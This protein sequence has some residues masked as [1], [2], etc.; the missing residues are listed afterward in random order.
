MSLIFDSFLSLLEQDLHHGQQKAKALASHHPID[1]DRAFGHES[2]WFVWYDARNQAILELRSSITKKYVG[3][4]SKLER[5]SDESRREAALQNWQKCQVLCNLRN[6]TF[7]DRMTADRRVDPLLGFDIATR[8][9]LVATRAMLTR[10][11]QRSEIA[12]ASG[13]IW[14]S[15]M[16][17]P[18]VCIDSKETSLYDK[19]FDS[20]CMAHNPQILEYWD[21]FIAERPLIADAWNAAVHAYGAPMTNT[22]A[23]SLTTVPK[24]RFK[25][26]T[27]TKPTCLG[28]FMTRAIGVSLEECLSN[29]GLDV[30]TQP[31][32]NRELARIGSLDATLGMPDRPA[33]LDMRNASLE[34]LYSELIVYLFGDLPSLLT[35]M[36]ATREDVVGTPWGPTEVQNFSEMGNGFTFPLQTLVF[37]CLAVCTCQY[38]RIRTRPSRTLRSVA[39]APNLETVIAAFGDDLIVPEAAYER[40]DFVFT[41]IGITINRSKSFGP[42]SLFKESCGEDYYRGYNVR[43]V[44]CERL[45]TDRDVVSLLNRLA[46][47]S[48][49]W[50]VPLTRALTFLGRQLHVTRNLN[51]VPLWE[52]VDAGIMVPSELIMNGYVRCNLRKTTRIAL[53]LQPDGFCYRPFRPTALRRSLDGQHK[54][55]FSSFSGDVE[56][57][58]PRDFITQRDLERG[59]YYSRCR[60]ANASGFLAAVLSSNLSGTEV[61]LRSDDRPEYSQG[62]V[63]MVPGWD[64]P[65]LDDWALHDPSAGPHFRR[66]RQL[67]PTGRNSTWPVLL[68]RLTIVLRRCFMRNWLSLI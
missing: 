52:T 58:I 67:R 48:A 38:F 40:I 29:L 60:V 54:T 12:A 53:G 65:V 13:N 41:D 17:G 14:E 16:T 36:L 66:L 46:L 31:D 27:I 50:D 7:W 57:N 8:E 33:T 23:G 32:R 39:D 6:S 9:I 42:G 28:Q 1:H 24:D 63:V 49:D 51:V 68:A 47:W 61:G 45:D 15:G 56:F 62:D 19:L 35:L 21:S 11:C 26:R 25:D 64:Y 3:D 30:D 59:P 10:V 5:A 22:L 34:G 2:D 20:K 18:G 37:Y 44:F 4:S 43:G 55:G